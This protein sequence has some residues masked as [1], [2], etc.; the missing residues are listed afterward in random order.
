[1]KKNQGIIL[2]DTFTSEYYYR[3]GEI[4][5]TRKEK[6]KEMS[7]IIPKNSLRRD[8]SGHLVVEGLLIAVI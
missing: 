6:P 2:K 5:S 8:F 7:I 1:M 3:E 4:I